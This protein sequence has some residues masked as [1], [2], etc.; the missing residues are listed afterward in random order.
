MPHRLNKADELALICSHL[1]VP[2]HERS[3]EEGEWP[4]AL[5][6]YRTEAR[7]GGIIVHHELFAEVGEMQDRS[8]GQG[9]LQGHERRLSGRGPLER[10]SLEQLCE[11][12]R[13]GAV[14]LN[15]TPVVSGQAQEPVQAPNR[16]RLWPGLYGVHLGAVHRDALGRDHVAKVLDR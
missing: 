10:V 15:K 13:D 3:T 4:R 6:K 1:E 5:V 7:P 14:V 12:T 11:W 16:A 9:G 8:T 2:G